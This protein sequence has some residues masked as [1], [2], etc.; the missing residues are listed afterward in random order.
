MENE[1][2]LY[3]GSGGGPLGGGGLEREW[4]PGKKKELTTGKQR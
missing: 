1:E 4:G 2:G 3:V